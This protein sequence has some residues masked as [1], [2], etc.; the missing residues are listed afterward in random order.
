[1]AGLAGLGLGESC[2]KTARKA[3]RASSNSCFLRHK[4]EEGSLYLSIYPFLLLPQGFFF[5]FARATVKGCRPP[6]HARALSLSLC[7]CL[8]LSLSLSIS[9][10]LSLCCCSHTHL[11]ALP[12]PS[13]GL[14]PSLSVS[15][16]HVSCIIA[17][18]RRFPWAL[19]REVE[20]LEQRIQDPL[21]EGLVLSKGSGRKGEKRKNKGLE[22][23][24]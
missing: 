6:P 22:S 21:V 15:I 18:P 14:S 3:R 24:V 19:R 1:M 5:F 10:S 8:C 2:L 17:S 16:H 13:V 4:M 9:L 12:C 23:R 7:L 20:A 11:S